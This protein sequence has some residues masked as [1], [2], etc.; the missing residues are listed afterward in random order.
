MVITAFI[1]R[2]IEP[3]ER[4]ISDQENLIKNINNDLNK[5]DKDQEAIRDE[6]KKFKNESDAIIK[7]YTSFKI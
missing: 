4:Q 6:L 1:E 3:I 2:G 5:T 7:D